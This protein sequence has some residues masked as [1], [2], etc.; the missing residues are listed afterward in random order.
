MEYT[1]EMSEDYCCGGGH[2][3]PLPGYEFHCP[4]CHNDS[5]CRTGYPLKLG[6]TFKCL[7]CKEPLKVLEINEKMFKLQAVDKANAS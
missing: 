2:C 7:K 1:V 4:L 5:L 6:Q 3:G